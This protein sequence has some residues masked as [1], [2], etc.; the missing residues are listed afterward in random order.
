M[1]DQPKPTKTPKVP[2]K[3]PAWW[4]AW[5]RFR[6]HTPADSALLAQ[7]S[8]LEVQWDAFVAEMEEKRQAESDP[9]SSSGTKKRKTSNS[10]PVGALIRQLDKT[11]PVVQEDR[12][13]KDLLYAHLQRSLSDV[14][15][16]ILSKKHHRQIQT[17][18]PLLDD[19]QDLKALRTWLCD[20]TQPKG[21]GGGG[22]SSKKARHHETEAS[23]AS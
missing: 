21:G 5:L 7:L 12:V 1:A 10:D 11:I 14:L 17:Y 3:P 20:L 8:P 6:G 22:G 23:S 18:I 15:P 9:H 19:H 13:Q 4:S 2:K 16:P